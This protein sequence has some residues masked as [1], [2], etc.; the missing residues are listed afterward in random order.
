MQD[1]RALR[2]SRNLS[3]WR[4]WEGE[5]CQ[6]SGFAA[7]MGGVLTPLTLAF[8]LSPVLFGPALGDRLVPTFVVGLILF[9]GTSFALM[10]LAV[11]RVKGWKSANPWTPPS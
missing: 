11:W 8:V 10:A 3:S 5:A 4:A 2:N 9:L 7:I 1:I 6:R